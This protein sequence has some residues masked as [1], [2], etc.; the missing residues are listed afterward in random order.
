MRV[1]LTLNKC[2][3]SFQNVEQQDQMAHMLANVT[4]LKDLMKREGLD[5][6]VATCPEN[7]TYLSGFWAMSQWVR[8]GPQAYVLFPADGEPCLIANSGILDLV[9]D[10][11]PWVKDVRRYGYF[12]IDVDASVELDAADRLQKQLFGSKAY[13]GSV[14]ALVEAAREKGLTRAKIGLDEMGITPQCMDQLSASMPDAQFV[15]SFSLFERVRSVKTPGEIEILRQAA[16]ITERAIDAALAVAKEGISEREM[17]RAFN[18]CLAQNDAAPVVGCI[19]FGNRSGMI[20]VQPS[21]RELKKGD[22]I[23][24]DVGGR[25][26]H[27]RSDMSRGASLG[28]PD[29]RIEKYY[30][31]VEK[32]VLRAYDV[33]KPGFKVADLFKEVVETVRREG[34]P[35]FKRSHVGHGIGVDGYDPPNISEKT[36]EVFE[37]NMVICVETPYY[38]LGFAGLQ[39]EDM[40][41]VTKDGAESLMSLP[42]A[43]R[44]I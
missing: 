4:R 6:V 22:L 5:A 13:D 37:E 31:A 24:F 25:F 17:L 1:P 14:E 7:V 44:I 33:V 43:L 16:R 12:Q 9:P 2:E 20:N 10:Q 3:T 15:R 19:G 34:I 21:D 32:G 29:P 28:K 35:H 8:R 40:L 27:Y 36:G 23:R 18:A 26:R 42:T 41:R 11:D 38:E 30:R 39:V